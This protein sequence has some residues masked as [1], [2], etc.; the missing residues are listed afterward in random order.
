MKW[1]QENERENYDK[2][3][4]II[5]PKD[6]IRFKI[7]GEIGV[8][9]TDASATLLFDIEK[10]KWAI[11]LIEK[12]GFDINMLPKEIHKPSDIAGFIT[13]DIVK[14]FNMSE[15]TAVV[16]GGSD[17]AMQLI[18]S[19]VYEKGVMTVTL[20]SGAQTVML[21]DKPI[22]NPKL[23]THL[24]LSAIPNYWFSMGAVL[25]AG[26]AFTWLKRTFFENLSYREMDELAKEI[27]PCS[28]NL[29]F[30][31]CIAGERTPYLDSKTRGIFLGATYIHTKGDFIRATMEGIA[32]SIKESFD[33]LSERG[34]N[35]KKIIAAGGVV[36][37]P[38]W[39]QIIAD[40]L[41]KEIWLNEAKEQASVGACI[42]AGIG[43][44]IFKNEEEACK[45]MIKS[46]TKVIKPI[47]ENI[48]KYNQF[49]NNIY[50]EIY[51]ANKGIFDKL[52]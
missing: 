17:Q 11:D 45:K 47:E 29:V 52:S 33:L 34:Y 30:F 14:E 13:A 7:C 46:P 20:G 3:C 16:Y 51:K 25:N 10:K 22:A 48:E 26:L 9:Y 15:K 24:F 36:N 18:G 31:P 49:F 40:I 4:K 42:E 37:S 39:L 50:K 5:S 21:E 41:G 2:I 19:G 32:F 28:N 8:E 6:Y 38:L 27:P 44:N 23:N 35:P 1:V 43:I 12:C